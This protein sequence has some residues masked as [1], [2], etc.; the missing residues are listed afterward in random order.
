LDF[1]KINSISDLLNE[2]DKTKNEG[3]VVMNI[4]KPVFQEEPE[5]GM[6]VA[7]TILTELLGFHEA[8]MS[9]AIEDGES[10]I[11]ANWAIDCGRIDDVITTLKNI[12][13]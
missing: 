3:D 12:Q 5:V 9:Q 4:C 10:T 11:V 1:S 2:N 6:Q 13:M 7:I 8:V